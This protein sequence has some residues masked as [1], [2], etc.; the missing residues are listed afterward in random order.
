MRWSLPRIEM[1]CQCYVS[2][3]TAYSR[4]FRHPSL[5]ISH[6]VHRKWGESSEEP[7]PARAILQ[8][9]S[10]NVY[11]AANCS[12]SSEVSRSFLLHELF[13]QCRSPPNKPLI[14]KH[15]SLFGKDFSYEYR[16]HCL[17]LSGAH[18]LDKCRYRK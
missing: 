1:I 2:G 15:M 7:P 16:V 10:L 3:H 17:E 6:K 12:Q 11:Q 14:A 9:K 8:S 18:G 4:T 13:P 5:Y